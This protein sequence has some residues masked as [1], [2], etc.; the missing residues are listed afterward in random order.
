[1][2]EVDIKNDIPIYVISLADDV[3]RREQ[4]RKQFPLNYD[5]FQF[6][7]AIDFRGKRKEEISDKYKECK[8]NRK[9][10][11]TPTEVACSLSHQKAIEKFLLSKKD[12]C[13]ILE[14]DVIGDDKS[15]SNALQLMVNNCT[16]SFV[17]FGGQQGLKNAK[18]I[19]GKFAKDAYELNSMS[20]IFCTRACAYAISR[21]TASKFFS[22]K[23]RCLDR[24]DRWDKKLKKM[25]KILFLNLFKH[26]VNLNDSHLEKERLIYKKTI[27]RKMVAD[28]VSE[29]IYRTL[30][31]FWLNI[32]K[33]FKRG[34][35]ILK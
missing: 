7:E 24:A 23:D 1:M 22:E 6:I 10:P 3:A 2:N 5:S 20:L 16:V 27:F 35:F 12:W 18:Y 25:E 15:I 31:K 21:E 28:G 30:I 26:P 11:L 17:L 9:R 32:L 14:D 34:E 33:I 13:L 4:L 8:H 19:F 29:I